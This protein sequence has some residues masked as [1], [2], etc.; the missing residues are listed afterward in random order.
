MGDLFEDERLARLLRE[1][2]FEAVMH[3][4]AF[5]LVGESVTDPAKY[6]QNN[7]VGT[8]ALLEAMRAA[9][10][11]RIVFSSTTATYGEPERVPIT[12]AEPQKP[13][14]PYGFAKLVI[15]R[16][17]PIMPRL[18]ALATRRYVT[19]TP[20]A[21]PRAARLARITGPNRI[22]S[23]SCC[24]WRWGS[25]RISRSSAKITPRRMEPAFATTFT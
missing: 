24:R 17:W 15:E 9:G 21:P 16:R 12:E 19:S 3:F 11:W 4:A 23:R 6:Y 14:N 10:V 20:P 13:I 2:R 1:E 7:V 18:T 22:S 25:G 8:L 5:S